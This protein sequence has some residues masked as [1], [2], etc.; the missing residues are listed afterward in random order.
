V[1]KGVFDENLRHTHPTVLSGSREEL[2]KMDI[3][4]IVEKG[5]FDL[6]HRIAADYELD[7]DELC[8]RYMSAEAPKV[9]RGRSPSSVCRGKTAKGQACKKK[10]SDGCD[11]YCKTHAPKDSDGSGDEVEVPV[12]CRSKTAK[13]LPCKKKAVDGGY[14]KTHAPKEE[15]ESEAEDESVVI[16]RG[17]TGK[18]Q[19]CKKKASEGC[20]G[21]CK[22]HKDSGPFKLNPVHA[23]GPEEIS[24]DCEACSVYGDP[25]N[26]PPQ[27]KA[28]TVVRRSERLK[29]V[30]VEEDDDATQDDDDMAAY[31]EALAAEMRDQGI[32]DEIDA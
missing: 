30:A 28:Y 18:K 26:S 7:Y 17:M 25:V 6:L 4:L 16:C 27:K 23:H 12:T 1:L 22:T 14:C 5:L 29:Q 31:A 32:L 20:N 8:E 15:L 13:G 3:Q 19:P 10:A 9:S 24:E 11:G 2:L 21:F